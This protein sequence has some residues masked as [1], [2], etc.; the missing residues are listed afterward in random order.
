MAMNPVVDFSDALRK[1][2]KFQIV[3]SAKIK[4]VVEMIK[5]RFDITP[6]E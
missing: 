5:V 3:K 2:E 6:D 1:S 4:V